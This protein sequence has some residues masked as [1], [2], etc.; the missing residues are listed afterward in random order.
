MR[1]C[2]AQAEHFRL[3]RELQLRAEENKLC[4]RVRAACTTT[5]LAVADAHANA[6]P[7]ARS[8]GV[9]MTQAE[10]AAKRVALQSYGGVRAPP[11][12]AKLYDAEQARSVRSRTRHFAA[13]SCLACPPAHR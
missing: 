8:L 11:G 10:E 1:R 6:L 3:K 7:P 5:Q 13:P 9:R 2:A 12:A 4:V